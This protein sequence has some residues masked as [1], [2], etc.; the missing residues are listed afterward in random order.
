MN[1][2]EFYFAIKVIAGFVGA[3]ACI[4]YLIFFFIKLH[5]INKKK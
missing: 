3:V 1:F 5:N 2:V 4:A